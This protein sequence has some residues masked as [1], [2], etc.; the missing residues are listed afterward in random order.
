MRQM[1]TPNGN[2]IN[3]YQHIIL[4]NGWEYYVTSRPT[5]SDIIECL[6]MGFETEYGSVSLNEIKPYIISRTI[7]LADIMPA[8]GHRWLS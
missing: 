7:D 1:L 4:R 2:L 3:V 8:T 6:V 5:K